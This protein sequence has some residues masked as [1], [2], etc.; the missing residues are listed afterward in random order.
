MPPNTD[1]PETPLM[2]TQRQEG[3]DSKPF[4]LPIQELP[5]TRQR[6]KGLIITASILIIVTLFGSILYLYWQNTHKPLSAAVQGRA[7]PKPTPKAL[8][9]VIPYNDRYV[10]IIFDHPK[11]WQ[12][13]SSGSDY[14]QTQIVA[15]ANK[16]RADEKL[17]LHISYYKAYPN[18]NPNASKKFAEGV[19]LKPKCP[20]DVTQ[21]ASSDCKLATNSVTPGFVYSDKGINGKSVVRWHGQAG[22]ESFDIESYELDVNTFSTIIKSIKSSTSRTGREALV[23]IAIL[24]TTDKSENEKNVQTIKLATNDM[25]LQKCDGIRGITYQQDPYDKTKARVLEEWQTIVNCQIG[26]QGAI[27]SYKGNTLQGDDC[28]K[29]KRFPNLRKILENVTVLSARDG[30]VA[31]VKTKDGNQ[32]VSYVDKYYESSVPWFVDTAC[33]SL[34]LSNLKVGDIISVYVP[35]NDQSPNAF[36]HDTRVVQKVNNPVR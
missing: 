3:G 34:D 20:Y 25:N 28:S 17:V 35:V 16:G 21:P 13:T 9:E 2:P 30:R 7:S 6:K 5:E 36:E 23:P 19:S 29:L 32:S 18:T 27:K 8:S 11:E 10:P 12:L 22:T 14:T 33:G 1:K 4:K 24:S 26:V 31:L 15:Y